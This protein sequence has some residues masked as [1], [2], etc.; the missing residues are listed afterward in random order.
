MHSTTVNGQP[1][2]VLICAPSGTTNPACPLPAGVTSVPNCTAAL[3]TLSY[4]VSVNAV[5]SINSETNQITAQLPGTTVVTAS[6][7]GS[8]S[9]AGYFT[10]CPPASISVTSTVSQAP[11][12]L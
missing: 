2:N 4:S 3:G 10:T 11:P 1:A 7:A 12:T 5:A 6:V 8:G 9:S